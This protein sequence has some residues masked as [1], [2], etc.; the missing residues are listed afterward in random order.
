MAGRLY[1]GTSGFAYPSWAPTF[2]PEG[3]RADGLLPFYSAHLPACELNNTFYRHPTPERIAEWIRSTPP[4]FRFTVKA[5]RTGS[6]RAVRT[7]PQ[8]T[9]PWLTAPL[10]HFGDRLGAVLLRVPEEQQRDDDR[11]G[12]FLRRW[13]SELPLAMEFQ[14]PSWIADEVLAA[15]QKVGAVLC[16]TELDADPLPPTIRLTGGFLYLRLRRSDYEPAEIDAWAARLAPFLDDDRDAYV[17]FR[18]DDEGQAP[19]RAQALLSAVSR[20]SAARR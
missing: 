7:D 9:L 18:H 14:H 12:E 20:T 11:L 17:F 13:P 16:L 15:L 5:L 10:R 4:D 8:G 6:I 19:M 3:T 2:Y 1:A